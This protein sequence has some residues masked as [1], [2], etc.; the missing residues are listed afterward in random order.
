MSKLDI[1]KGDDQAKVGRWLDD[2]KT[3]P[4]TLPETRV[5]LAIRNA[6]AKGIRTK[7]AADQLEAVPSELAIPIRDLRAKGLI[8]NVQGNR[9]ALTERAEELLRGAKG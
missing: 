9:Y 4:I 5:L 6:G 1:A 8:R 2:D 3:V 7:T